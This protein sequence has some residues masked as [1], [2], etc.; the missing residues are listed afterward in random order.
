[1]INMVGVE[2]AH[3]PP[4]M[5]TDI[6]AVASAMPYNRLRRNKDKDREGSKKRRNTAL[7]LLVD[8]ERDE[9]PG[10]MGCFFEARA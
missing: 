1:M 10:Q 6:P 5:L 7:E 8:K 4:P 3:D 2:Y 9:M